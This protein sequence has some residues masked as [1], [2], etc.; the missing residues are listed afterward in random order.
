[1]RKSIVLFLIVSMLLH[2]SV[3]AQNLLTNGS[4][5]VPVLTGQEKSMFATNNTLVGWTIGPTGSIYLVRPPAGARL[6]AVDGAQYVDLNGR[7]LTLSQSFTTITGQVYEVRFAVGYYQGTNFS[8]MQLTAR[9]TSDAGEL[10]GEWTVGAPRNTGWNAPSRF[11][12]TAV[13]PASTLTFVDNTSTV[14]YD[15]TLDD[16]SVER[17]TPRLTIV[18]SHVQVCWESQSNRLYQLQYRPDLNSPWI[19]L[20]EPIAGTGMTNCVTEQVTD[21]RRFFR[22]LALP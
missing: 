16:V 13:S 4:F 22:A 19:D 11:R 6:A 2:I 20:G 21:T 18:C 10:L 12:F 14:N 7:G 5:E 3:R 1:M 15:L 9:V 17:A 8:N